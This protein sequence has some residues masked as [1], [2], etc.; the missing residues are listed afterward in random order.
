LTL[1]RL[2]F[3]EF[4]PAALARPESSAQQAANLLRP[5]I[6]SA[7]QLRSARLAQC[8]RSA[9]TVPHTSVARSNCG[10]KQAQA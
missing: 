9:Q 10:L 8:V 2:F 3:R 1:E 4:Q 5:L 7:S 6:A